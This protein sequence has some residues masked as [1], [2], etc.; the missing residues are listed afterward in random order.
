MDHNETRVPKS[1]FV[2]DSDLWFSGIENSMNTLGSAQVETS[3]DL[4]RLQNSDI[5]DC[6][7][8]TGNLVRQ[9]MLE[10]S[11][12]TDIYPEEIKGDATCRKIMTHMKAKA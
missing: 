4:I 10:L 5:R 12:N 1:Y 9:A 8:V 2:F 6:W 7:V 3:D 11:K